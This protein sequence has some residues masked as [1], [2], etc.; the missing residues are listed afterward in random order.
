MYLAIRKVHRSGKVKQRTHHAILLLLPWKQKEKRSSPRDSQDSR[1][2]AWR[3]RKCGEMRCAFCKREGN[4]AHYSEHLKGC[5]LE[6]PIQFSDN[7]LTSYSNSG[8]YY[9]TSN[10]SH[11]QHA[12]KARLVKTCQRLRSLP[13]SFPLTFSHSSCVAVH[14]LYCITCF[15]NHLSHPHTQAL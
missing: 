6:F 13:V 5:D 2:V 7:T 12:A 9:A 8:V 11:W 14:I 4:S 1:V 15:F 3:D 10:M